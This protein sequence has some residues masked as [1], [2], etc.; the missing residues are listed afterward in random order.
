M[1]RKEYI[2]AQSTTNGWR[3]LDRQKLHIREARRLNDFLRKTN[4][5]SRWILN[6]NHPELAIAP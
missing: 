1:N 6:T 3:I 4:K 5:S 2:L